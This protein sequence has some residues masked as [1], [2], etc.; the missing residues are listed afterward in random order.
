MTN[1]T[2]N[3]M[4]PFDPAV[5]AIAQSRRQS[6]DEVFNSTYVRLE[7][8]APPVDNT[9][10]EARIDWTDDTDPTSGYVL[11]TKSFGTLLGSLHARGFLTGDAPAG[12]R[13][14][15]VR[16]VPRSATPLA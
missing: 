9:V 13:L 6:P 8:Q 14:A 7:E 11:A 10:W 1:Q 16:R 5:V 12:E 3:V 4:S 15:S 2:L